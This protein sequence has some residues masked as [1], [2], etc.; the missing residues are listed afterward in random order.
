MA[1]GD[2]NWITLLVVVFNAVIGYFTHRD[3]NKKD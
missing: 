3:V 1:G 2:V